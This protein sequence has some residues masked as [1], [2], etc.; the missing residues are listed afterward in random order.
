ML[1]TA[2]KLASFTF[3]L[4]IHSTLYINKINL[5]Y[6]YQLQFKYMTKCF[7]LTVERK[8]N[9][10][11]YFVALHCKYKCTGVNL[12]THPERLKFLFLIYSC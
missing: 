10:Y 9:E 12:F 2:L 11:Q 5:N 8:T 1:V 7:L 6:Q 3:L 4:L